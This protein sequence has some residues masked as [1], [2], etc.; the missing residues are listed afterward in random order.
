MGPPTKR[1]GAARW[2]SVGGADNTDLPVEWV[3]ES[4]PANWTMTAYAVCATQ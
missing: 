4:Y 1:D 2:H 3:L